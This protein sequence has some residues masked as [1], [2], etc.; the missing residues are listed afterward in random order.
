[1]KKPNKNMN[2]RGRKNESKAQITIF[3]VIA[4]VIVFIILIISFFLF[5]DTKIIR[6][7]IKPNS[8]SSE[9]IPVYESID[10]CAYQRS[11]DAIR[12]VGLQ[13]GY[14][15]LPEKNVR[16]QFGNVAYGYYDG[17]N[18]L[19]KINQIQDE[20]N[21]YISFTVPF[22]AY[23][24]NLNSYTIISN[25]INSSTKIESNKVRVKINMPIYIYKEN[26]TF[27][28]DKN[29]DFEIPIKLGNMIE[30]ANEII[31]KEIDN[32][33]YL[34]IGH[35]SG[36]N[37]DSLIIYP[38]NTTAL[39]ILSSISDKNLNQNVSYNFL[40]SNDFGGKK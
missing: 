38:D 31:K 10:N 13:G 26:K 20:I 21:S 2:K 15:T 16:T 1:M 14:V 3:I 11:I 36:I 5:K 7:I 8:V 33:G 9:V 35:I 17:K 28:L 18:V 23:N 32:P 19:P 22:C 39:I 27:S 12:I 25:K 4:I 30:T 6:D 29:Y 37:Y 34:P 24:Q 40:F